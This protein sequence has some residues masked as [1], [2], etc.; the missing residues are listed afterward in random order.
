MFI[1]KQLGR[2]PLATKWPYRSSIATT[3]KN[4]IIYIY[5]NQ[6]ANLVQGGAMLT[7]G[8]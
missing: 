2:L 8:S 1:P 3:R 4:I 6:Q 5:V 7:V